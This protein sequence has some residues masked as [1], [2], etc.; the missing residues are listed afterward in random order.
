[1]GPTRSVALLDV[2]RRHTTNAAAQPA[3]N[4]AAIDGDRAA[5]RSA[6]ST[7][8]VT[9]PEEPQGPASAAP[10]PVG[11]V[12]PPS[13][14]ER[15]AEQFM[16]ELSR[17]V[18]RSPTPLPTTYR[19]MADAITGGRTVMLSTDPASRRALR[20]VRKVAATTGDT[21]HLDPVSVPT[22]RLDEVI[23]HELTH[24]AHPSPTPRFFDDIDDSPEERK[25][26]HVARVMARSP[27]APSASVVSPV[28]RARSGGRPD[29]IRRAP[30]PASAAAS[31]S[32]SSPG[33]LSADALA[34]RLTGSRSP[35]A[36]S[37]I[38]RTD[39]IRRSPAPAPVSPSEPPVIRRFLDGS[40]STSSTVGSSTASQQT[41]LSDE[42]FLER[43]RANMPEIMS[44][45]EDR[46]IIE[47]ERRGGRTW[48]AL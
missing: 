12:E 22:Q 46:M 25:A 4:G 17:T 45:I 48:G 38:A 31:S 3:G 18:R 2:I 6:R 24:V 41:E 26:E 1:M 36:S 15:L 19:P 47:L 14:A 5:G 42:E 27:L 9:S 23:A 29:V 21:I 16:V 32:S 44:L 28:G 30:A 34:A 43:F 33:T 8:S 35:T 37:P 39:T 13:P 40:S 11:A 10:T 7:D 20:S